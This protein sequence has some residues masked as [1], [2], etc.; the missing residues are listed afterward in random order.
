MC[1]ADPSTGHMR[2]ARSIEA[3][4]AGTGAVNQLFAQVAG[5]R[6]FSAATEVIC[7]SKS[8]MNVQLAALSLKLAELDPPFA[9]AYDQLVFRLITAEAGSAAPKEGEMMPD[10]LLPSH[11]GE[12]VSLSGLLEKG[13]V[14]LSFNRGHW[15]NFCRIELR[16]IAGAYDKIAAAGADVAV[17]MP[18][19]PR[20]TA[21][22]VVDTGGKLKVLSDVD[23]GYALSAGLVMWVGEQI[24]GL[25]RADQINM[26]LY[27][28]NQ[29][30]FLPLPATYI[31]GRD[32]LIR[33]RFVNPDFRQRLGIE[34]I[35]ESLE[36]LS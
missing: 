25:M 1:P 4:M 19:L 27:Q 13:S 36:R 30:W 2:V 17:I 11:S 34:S 10:F 28:G 9:A 31:V 12:L 24:A 7:Q 5:L 20:Y 3:G 33:K 14:V 21:K 8:P 18:D 26:P 29:G 15:C 32:G 35:L 23:N 22:T 6:S 16:A